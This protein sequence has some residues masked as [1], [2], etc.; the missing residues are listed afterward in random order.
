MAHILALTTKPGR[1]NHDE[2]RRR[3]SRHG[4]HRRRSAQRRLLHPCSRLAPGREDRQPGRPQRLSP[5]LRGRA[6]SAWRGPDLFRVSGCKAWPVRGRDGAPDRLARRLPGGARLLGRPAR[7]R[8]SE[9]RARRRCA[10][11]RG[12]RRARPRARRK[13]GRGRA[14][15][16]RTTPRSPPRLPFKGSR[17]CARTA[18]GPRRLPACSNR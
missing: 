12:L 4:D 1:N 17:A 18:T 6:C 13:H 7:R 8:R 15:R 16:R 2:I 9:L 10:A 5:L 3:S 11:L 14:A